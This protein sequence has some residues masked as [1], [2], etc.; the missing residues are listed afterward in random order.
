VAFETR[1]SPK[2]LGPAALLRRP[3]EVTGSGAP[4]FSALRFYLLEPAAV[5][6]AKVLRGLSCTAWRNAFSEF[7]ASPLLR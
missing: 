5:A 2:P 4:F 1:F 3:Q 6:F 7:G